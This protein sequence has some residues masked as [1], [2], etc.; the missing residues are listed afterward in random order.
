MK[1]NTTTGTRKATPSR[2]AR[3]TRAAFNSRAGSQ[4]IIGHDTNVS[5]TVANILREK[6]ANPAAVTSLIV[7]HERYDEVWNELIQ[8]DAIVLSDNQRDQL[9]SYIDHTMPDLEVQDE[10]VSAVDFAARAGINVHPVTRV[11]VA[12]GNNKDFYPPINR[13]LLGP[14]LTLYEADDERE[15]AEIADKL[16]NQD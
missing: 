11:L 3:P 2:A 12:E 16:A 4:A 6:T 1:A 15:A 13:S 8:Q 10:A 5:Q 14:V 9:S 7:E